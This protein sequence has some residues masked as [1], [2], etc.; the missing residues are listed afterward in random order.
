MHRTS[1][2]DFQY[3]IFGLLT[4]GYDVLQQIENVPVQDNGSGEVS[5]PVNTV[6]ITSTPRSLPTPRTGMLRL[7]APVG[8]TGTADVTVTA[9]DSVTNESAQPDL[10][11]SPPRPTRHNDPPFLEKIEPDSNHGQHA[12][13]ASNIP[14]TDVEGDPIYYD[15]HRSARLKA[16]LSLTV[17]SSTGDCQLTPSNGIVGVFGIQ[18]GVGASTASSHSDTQFVPVYISPAAPTGIELVR[19][20]YRQQPTDNLTDLNNAT[21]ERTPVQGQRRGLG[22]GGRSVRRRHVDRRGTA[23]ASDTSV[24][25]TTN[26]TVTLTDGPHTITAKQTCTNQTVESAT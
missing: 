8:T 24:I 20:R 13:Q 7:S 1:P 26:G 17:D 12:G 21:R 18:V 22:R 11:T 6:T 19:F 9:T 23:G 14:A 16:N 10:S 4:Q 15:G 3:T 2:A 5:S 25:I